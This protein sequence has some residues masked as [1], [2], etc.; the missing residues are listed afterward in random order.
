MIDYYISQV[1]GERGGAGFERMVA[2]VV[3]LQFGPFWNQPEFYVATKLR[4]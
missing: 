2:E 4:D 3:P 1:E